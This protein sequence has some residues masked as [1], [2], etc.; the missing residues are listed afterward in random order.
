MFRDD[1]VAAARLTLDNSG[2]VGINTAAPGYTLDAQGGQINASGGLCIAGSCQTS[3]PTAI[4]TL[5]PGPG[6]TG[7][8]TGGTVTLG[9]AN[10]GI[11]TAQL[12]TGAVT[13]SQIAAGTIVDGN[14][15]GSAAISTSKLSQAARTRAIT[16]LAGC[17]SCSVLAS[18]DSQQKIYINLLSTMTIQSVSCY[19]DGGSST[20]NIAH[21]GA[22]ILT[23]LNTQTAS[24][25]TCTSGGNSGSILNAQST[26][27]TG[28]TLDFVM[29]NADRVTKRI[30]VVNLATLN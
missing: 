21:N 15:S 1:T 30:T 20:I 13:S 8:G 3:W 6:L 5:N 28:D 22:T 12:A 4:A 7:G 18:T 29:E 11:N 14:I 17:D 24:N 25:L 27:N 10:G 23:N 16:Y 9:V 26:L 2:R 19:A